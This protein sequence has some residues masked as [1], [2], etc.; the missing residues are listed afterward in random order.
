MSFLEEKV[1]MCF[2]QGGLRNTDYQPCRSTP[3]CVLHKVTDEL[4]HMS[5]KPLHIFCRNSHSRTCITLFPFQSELNKHQSDV[6]NCN[7]K[8]AISNLI[9][10]FFFLYELSASKGSRR[11]CGQ[12]KCPCRKFRIANYFLTEHEL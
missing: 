12:R 2:H 10:S 5:H 3:N 7:M 1:D 4:C 11:F 8:H 6:M 9:N